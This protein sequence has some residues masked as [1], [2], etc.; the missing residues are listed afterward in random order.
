MRSRFCVLFFFLTVILAVA[1]TASA[2]YSTQLGRFISRDPIGYDGG[3]NLCAYEGGYPIGYVDPYGLQPPPCPWPCQPNRPHWP[4]GRPSLP[5]PDGSQ[6]TQIKVPCSNALQL[7]QNTAG[8]HIAVNVFPA[9]D[10]SDLNCLLSDAVDSLP[11]GSPDCVGFLELLGNSTPDHFDLGMTNAC[12]NVDL[13]KS[14]CTDLACT[15]VSGIRFCQPCVIALTGC[16]SGTQVSTLAD[17]SWVQQLANETGCTV[18]GTGGYTAT[19]SS[20][21]GGNISVGATGNTGLPDP[22]WPNNAYLPQ[23]DTCYLFEPWTPEE[24][25]AAATQRGSGHP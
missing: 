6:G 24:E 3:V 19:D 1:E 7:V 10:L 5:R 9:H 14:T 22:N 17:P 20:F 18:I 12:C 4:V 21:T 16:N 8:S 13:D 15:L 11:P 23:A 25:A 2:Y